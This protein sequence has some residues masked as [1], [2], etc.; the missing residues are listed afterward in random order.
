MEKIKKHNPPG[1][2]KQQPPTKEEKPCN[3]QKQQEDNETHP[4]TPLKSTN[5]KT[6][7]ETRRKYVPQAL[8]P[9]KKGPEIYIQAT[10]D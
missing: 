8:K 4:S 2:K 3:K 7:Q 9:T 6:R 5:Y 10:Q 1:K